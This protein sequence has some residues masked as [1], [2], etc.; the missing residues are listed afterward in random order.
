MSGALLLLTT[1]HADPLA[2]WP[3]SMARRAGLLNEDKQEFV[4]SLVEL[5]GER[6]NAALASANRHAARL[7]LRFLAALVVANVLHAS[8]VIAALTSL[9][10]AATGIADAGVVMLR[11]GRLLLVSFIRDWL[12]ACCASS[13]LTGCG[14]KGV[15]RRIALCMPRS[16]L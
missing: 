13:G 11:A 2:C 1:M 8:S 4:A 12:F 9:V 7:L 3:L 5:A 15:R 16:T 14:D 10:E 6:F